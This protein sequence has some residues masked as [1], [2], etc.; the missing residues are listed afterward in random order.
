MTL[1][2]LRGSVTRAYCYDRTLMKAV[3]ISFFALTSTSAYAGIGRPRSEP[4]LWSY[5]ESSYW[6]SSSQFASEKLA[7]FRA[8]LA[9]RYA[10]WTTCPET[11]KPVYTGVTRDKPTIAEDERQYAPYSCSACG[12]M[13]VWKSLDVSVHVNVE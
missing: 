5:W 12:K 10:I 8:M 9:I 4:A 13:H 6:A 1:V 3:T 11:G 2:C 7:L